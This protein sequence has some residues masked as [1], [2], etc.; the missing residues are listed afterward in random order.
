MNDLGEDAIVERNA[1]V[2]MLLS[3]D[4]YHWDLADKHK[5]GD[6]ARISVV[7]N[8]QGLRGDVRV[9]YIEECRRFENPDYVEP[10]QPSA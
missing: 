8:A 1:D 6:Y 10:D 3:R 5:S 4:G 2:F 7:R 9:K